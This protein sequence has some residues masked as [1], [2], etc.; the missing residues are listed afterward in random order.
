ME[1]ASAIFYSD[2]AVSPPDDER[3]ARSRTRRRISG[4]ATRSPSANGRTCG[5]R[6]GSRRISPR[7]GRAPLVATARFGRRW[8]AFGAR[9]SPTAT[10]VTHRPV[11]DTI[12]TELLA[13]L[14]RNSYEKG[15]FVLHMLRAQ[16]GERAFFDA[17]RAYYAQVPARDGG[18]R[19]SARRD[20]ARVAA[21]ARLVLRPVA[22]AAGLSRGD[23]DVVIRSDGARS[24]SISVRAGARFGA[25]QFPLT[26][27][28]VDSSG[29][30]A[31]RRR[32]TMSRHGATR[33]S[34][35]AFRS[36]AAPAARRSRSGRRAA[37]ALTRRE[38]MNRM[39]PRAIACRGGRVVRARRCCRADGR[40]ARRFAACIAARLERAEIALLRRRARARAIRSR[41]LALGRYLVGARRAARRHDAARGGAAVRR[42]PVGDQRRTGADVSRARR[43]SHAQR[44]D[45]VAALRRAR[46]RAS[47]SWRIRRGSSRPTRSRRARYRDASRRAAMSA[48]SRFASTAGPSMRAIERASTGSSSSDTSASARARFAA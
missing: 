28:V 29:V 44:A 19:R 48:A 35:R 43:V 40:A 6:R 26:V 3:R 9:C 33:R 24:R 4:S 30:D 31:S 47:G 25:F 5:C 10:P 18:D 32:S 7:S 41:A 45:V 37:R 34:R 12:E 17:L 46:A 27:A 20:G 13:L 11:I 39:S 2:G 14:N 15:G 1:N 22:A 23:R 36:R 16:V 21:E 42:R 8:R 38:A